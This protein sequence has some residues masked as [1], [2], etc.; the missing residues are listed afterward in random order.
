MRFLRRIVHALVYHLY[1][2]RAISRTDVVSLFGLSLTIQ[3]SVFH[4]KFY[5]TSKFFAEYLRGLNLK[6]KEVLEI[7]SGSGILSLVAAQQE[8]RVTA[9]DINPRAVECTAHNAR[10]NGLEQRV[11][12][13]QSDLFNNIPPGPS[14]DIILWSPPFY[15]SDPVDEASHAWNAGRDYAVIQ[16]FADCAAS[17]L[18]EEGRVL[19]L[20]SSDT[21]THAIISIF[22]SRG[23]HVTLVREARK[24]FEV[25]S[26]YEFLPGADTIDRKKSR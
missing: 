8:A 20:L 18:R 11:R 22:E 15:P 1:V 24:L 14:F 9:V 23:F 10:T 26:I 25:L 19:F 6:G 4:P 16:H 17:Y 5:L 3:P 13:L 2:K 21:D 12:T 7:G